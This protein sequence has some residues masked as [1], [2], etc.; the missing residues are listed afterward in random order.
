MTQVKQWL[1]LD[2][3]DTLFFRGSD[4]MVSGENHDARTIFPPMP[5]TLLGAIRTAILE[6]RGIR[7][8]DFV[9][10]GGPDSEIRASFPF[11]GTPETPGFDVCGP[12]FHSELS[13]QGSDWFIPAPSYW[14]AK[15][16][17]DSDEDSD[18][19]SEVLRKGRE[20][21]DDLTTQGALN[22]GTRIDVTVARTSPKEIGELGLCGSVKDPSWLMEPIQGDPKSLAGCWTTLKSFDELRHKNS[23]C[24]VLR[25]CIGP[26]TAGE[27]ALVRLSTL[28][29][30]EHRVG[31]AIGA[32][33]R[34]VRSGYLYA[35][36]HVR[37]RQGFKLAIG[38]SQELIPTYLDPKGILKLGGEQRTA[39]YELVSQDPSFTKVQSDW[40]MSLNPSP[41][42]LLEKKGW[43]GNPRVS[44]AI[45][46]MA[47]WD[48]KERF[49]KR[50]TAYFPA[51][52]VVNV[53]PHEEAPFGFIRI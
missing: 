28:A 32:D 5:S 9:C 40:I 27:P 3:M 53:D 43:E 22:D 44:G 47:G 14:F 18:S 49:H 24:L 8:K 31:I 2:P 33:T 36:T 7:P 35:T 42:S 6:Q 12:I 37:L 45:I 30:S 48:M 16:P 50:V 39:G 1:L 21:S 29:A 51:G 46:R 23:G 17:L 26:M 20:A 25:G 38:L 13:D 52:T 11:L 4:P 34:K 10:D 41:T 15:L 19:Q